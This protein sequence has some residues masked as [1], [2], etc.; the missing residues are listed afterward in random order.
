MGEGIVELPKQSLESNLF[1]QAKTR[2]EKSQRIGNDLRPS[3]NT[4]FNRQRLAEVRAVEARST[5]GDEGKES[6]FE[7]LVI[8]TRG[9]QEKRFRMSYS[10]PNGQEVSEE[11]VMFVKTGKDGQP[12]WIT[13]DGQPLALNADLYD[14]RLQSKL[15][16]QGKDFNVNMMPKVDG[17]GA[18]TGVVSIVESEEA[19]KSDKAKVPVSG[20]KLA[21]SRL[22]TRQEAFGQFSQ[23]F[24]E[25][26]GQELEI[27][28]QNPPRP[29][30]VFPPIGGNAFGENDNPTLAGKL[31]A[32]VYNRLLDRPDKLPGSAQRAKDLIEA[33][34]KALEDF[35]GVLR[36]QTR[37]RKEMGKT[38]FTNKVK[39]E[40]GEDGFHL[41]GK[42]ELSRDFMFYFS[43][44][45]THWKNPNEP[46]V[47]AYVTLSQSEMNQVQRHFVDLATQMYDAGIDF[48]AKAQSPVG[49]SD[50]TDNMVF[51]ISASDQARASELMKKYLSGRAIGKGHVRAA[52][53]SPQEGLSWAFEPDEN[54]KKIW[55]EASGSSQGVSF[56]IFVATMAMP[57]YMERLA[58][59]H[60]K[61]GDTKSA[62][63]Y[64][65]EAE[66]VRSVIL[67][68]NTPKS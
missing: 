45:K 12:E 27:D 68:K 47:R 53:P 9:Y 14:S 41:E 23:E 1:D 10:S 6:G 33:S 56:N 54:Q 29:E 59:A 34:K 60:L 28:E 5:Q 37:T 11:L 2:I 22:S 18:Y 7:D 62:E 24:Y 46:E 13:H 26:I 61:K 50:R 42:T 63:T 52:V 32:R 58:L 8:D 21:E 48:T 43:K 66:R 30:A 4:E 51:Y 65:K 25:K 64:K 35:Q 40:A 44:S 39:R 67:T 20:T 55:Q 19:N 16:G 49:M 31:I 17:R 57:T 36:E 15:H 3:G 38:I